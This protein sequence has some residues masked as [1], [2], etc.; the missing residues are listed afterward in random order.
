MDRGD[1]MGWIL[2]ST[3]GLLLLLSPYSAWLLPG[4]G[5][6][7]L[8]VNATRLANPHAA[9]TGLAWATLLAEPVLLEWSARRLAAPSLPEWRQEAAGVGLAGHPTRLWGLTEG[10]MGNAGP[11]ATVNRLGLRGQ[12]PVVPRPEGVERILITGDSTFFG[13]GVADERT[14]GQS[15]VRG[16][17]GRGIVTDAID[18]GI[19]GYS[20]AQSRVLLDEVGWSLEPTMLLVG[21]LWSDNTV[22]GFHDADLL[23]TAA[24]FAHNPLRHSAFFLLASDYFHGAE[25]DDQLVVWT[26]ASRWPE[27]VERR[28]PIQQYAGNLDA[29]ARDAAARGTGIAF[30]APTTPTIL[31]GM[32]GTVSSW[33][34][35]FEAMREVAAWHGV[36]VV[37]F[38]EALRLHPA[39]TTAEFM[40]PIHPSALG[41]AAIAE[42]TTRVLVQA[43]WPQER[44]TA[45]D[46]PFDATH[47]VDGD[48]ALRRSEAT[49][50][51][52]AG[53][54]PTTDLPNSTAR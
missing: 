24:V 19:P 17:A 3:P 39:P 25:G 15:L 54:F 38:E 34:P 4:W 49:M 20:S 48:P 41:V 53:L 30:L 36:P 50:S 35:Y 22:N 16:L 13:H 28:V 51:L 14:L 44:L 45:T 26:T 1:W 10:Q 32:P 43:G 6:L 37:S 7:L 29:M 9:A 47:L 42:H 33:D 31:E 11:P 12:V 2:L 27:G 52:Q 40:D 18:G 46:V 8:A 23:R 21:N 5:V